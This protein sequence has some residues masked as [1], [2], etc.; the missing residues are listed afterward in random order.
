[1]NLIYKIYS[2]FIIIAISACTSGIRYSSNI[3]SENLLR[4]SQASPKNNFMKSNIKNNYISDDNTT[5]TPDTKKDTSS[6]LNLSEIVYNETYLPNNNNNIIPKNTNILRGI[7]SFY[8]IDF[9]GKQTS[10][11]EIFN[12]NDLTAAHRTLPFGTIVQV[13]NLKNGRKVVVRIN[14]RGPVPEDRI[15]DLSQASAEKLDMIQ[16]G[17][18]EVELTIISFSE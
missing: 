13:K 16:D 10:S 11:G 15:I 1:M 4:G 6:K 8:G 2:I 3:Y 5:E 18:V 9:N 12:M 17:V 14:D 7:A